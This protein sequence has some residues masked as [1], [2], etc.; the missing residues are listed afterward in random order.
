MRSYARA[1]GL[2]GLVLS[3]ILAA[4]FA[5]VVLAPAPLSAQAGRE[6]VI[7]GNRLYEEGRFQEAH[8]KY[9]EAMA[10]APESSIIPFNDGNA[11]YQDADYQRAMEAYQ[12]A[13]ETGDPALASA[14]WYNLGNALYRQQQL[15]PALEAYKQAL[16]MNPTDVDSKHNLERVLEQMQEQ[17]QQQQQDS[18]SEDDEENEDEQDSEQQSSPEDQ[19]QNQQ[20]NE[21]QDEG[22]GEGED[23]EEQPAGQQPQDQPQDGQGEPEPREGALSQEE[24]ERLLDAIDENPEDVNR[25][26][27][28]NRGRRPRKPW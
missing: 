16:R 6:R 3:G 15:E 28:S 22:D 14:A 11:L 20:Q 9:L 13:I 26:P 23:E 10:E 17:E 7:E 24:A 8:Q 4:A 27:A 12:R 2:G 18:D 1:R 5:A 21:Q 19:Q 25:K